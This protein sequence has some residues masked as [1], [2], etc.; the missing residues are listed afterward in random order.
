[1]L[2]WTPK[3]P[4]QIV[5]LDRR[6]LDPRR[7]EVPTPADQEEGLIMYREALPFLPTAYITHNTQVRVSAWLETS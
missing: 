7:P 3:S 5:A 6:F 1:M 2:I 4:L